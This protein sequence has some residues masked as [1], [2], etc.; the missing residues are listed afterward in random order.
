[1][2]K[3]IYELLLLSPNLTGREIAKK[4]GEEKSAVNL[5]LSKNH[6]SFSKNDTYHWS[7]KSFKKVV[8]EFD[9]IWIDSQAFETCLSRFPDLFAD[10]S[11]TIEFIF[12]KKC[13]FL[14]IAIAKLLALT[15]QL[16]DVC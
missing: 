6:D 12:P 15:N 10:T 13:K 9:P 1:M 8:I 5:F 16:V 11:A 4:I 14:L 7:V 2:K 3:K